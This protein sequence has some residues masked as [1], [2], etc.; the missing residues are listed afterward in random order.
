MKSYCV[1]DT[2]SIKILKGD[3]SSQCFSGENKL[4][5]LRV[6]KIESYPLS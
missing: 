3:T 5:G 1:L 6:L 4:F 2:D